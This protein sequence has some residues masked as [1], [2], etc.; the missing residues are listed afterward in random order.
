MRDYWQ[1]KPCLM[2]AAFPQFNPP[3]DRARLFEL[4]RDP[5]VE[6]RLISSSGQKWT[7]KSGP[8]PR[9]LPRES[10]PWTL[11]VQGVDLHD[12]AARDLLSRFRFVTDARLDDLMISYAT[13]GGGVGPHVDSYDVFL[14]QAAGQ[15]R[16][17]ISAQRNLRTSDASPL[18]H[19]SRFRAS[20]EWV[21]EPGDMLYL[22][23]GIP[24]EGVAVGECLTYSIGFRA[25]EYQQLLEPWLT[26]FSEHHLVRGR[27]AD[28]G[29]PAAAR[30]A[31][32]SPSMLR[33]VHSKLAQHRPTRAD[34]ERFLLRYLSEPKA[35]VI[36]ETPAQPLAATK[37]Q[38]FAL[39][40][41][42]K[43]DRKTRMIHSRN[44]MGING[45]CIVLS[46]KAVAALSRLADDRKLPPASVRQMPQSAWKLMHDWHAAGWIALGA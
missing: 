7:V 38:K 2:R 25:P 23:P 19:V 44:A 11:L 42:I 41:G 32:L 21:L 16:W 22:P 43:L 12:D 37:F 36:F 39:A 27:Y 20:D 18:R 24:H 13:H 31:A 8:L 9:R 35:S 29:V 15:R 45:E 26:D 4:A 10:S 33:Q 1:R 30:P 6:S 40:R 28:A 3:L 14:L 34:T 17:R 46:T 5:Q